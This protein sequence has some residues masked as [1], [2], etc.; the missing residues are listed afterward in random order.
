MRETVS[1]S[2]LRSAI[3]SKTCRVCALLCL[4]WA[5]IGCS[6]QSST[7]GPVLRRMLSAGRLPPC[8]FGPGRTTP[9]EDDGS[10]GGTRLTREGSTLEVPICPSPPSELQ[11]A[12]VGRSRVCNDFGSSP[13]WPDSTPPNKPPML[14][15]KT[16]AK[17]Q[18]QTFKLL[19]SVCVCAVRGPIG[20]DN[21]QSV[22]SSASH[23]PPSPSIST[24]EC[25]WPAT[26]RG[27]GTAVKGVTA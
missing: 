3:G 13:T 22:A 23:G 7:S 16:R 27:P 4:L 18:T 2:R 19:F 26:Y 14:A 10:E 17:W 1:R 12:Q 15:R 6:S 9:V 25:P 20:S 8:P 24:T 21:G 5:L 11:R